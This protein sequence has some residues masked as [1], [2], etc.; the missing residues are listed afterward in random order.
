MDAQ[1]NDGTVRSSWH[2]TGEACVES[3]RQVWKIPPLIV[4]TF[5]SGAI[6][7]VLL[8]AVLIH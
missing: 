5:V 8:W 3:S 2:F 4:F 6:C 7:M 1:H